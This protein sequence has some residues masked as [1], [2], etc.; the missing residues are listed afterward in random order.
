M[1]NISTNREFLA[2]TERQLVVGVIVAMLLAA[3][4]CLKHEGFQEE[5]EWR[6][7]YC[8]KFHSALMESTIKVV[9]GVPQIVYQIPLDASVA[10]DLADLDFSRVFNRLILGPSPYPWPMGNAFTE[11][12]AK[13][14]IPDA[15]ERVCASDIPIRTA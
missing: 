11:A 2:S 8:P 4:T 5:R 6:A 13:A 12:L 15:Q 9:S 1:D 7:I 10:P 14:G 3:V